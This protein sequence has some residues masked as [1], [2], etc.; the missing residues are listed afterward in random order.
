MCELQKVLNK[1]NIFDINVEATF[2]R[3]HTMPIAL[4]SWQG[5][6]CNNEVQFTFPTKYWF[7]EWWVFPYISCTFVEPKAFLFS[8]FLI[9]INK[10]T[11]IDKMRC[12]LSLKPYGSM[13]SKAW[14]ESTTKALTRSFVTRWRWRNCSFDQLQ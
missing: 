2:S 10:K 11:V 9:F 7:Y 14:R 13:P 6:P 1:Y 5:S 3:N 12:R 4:L 8:F